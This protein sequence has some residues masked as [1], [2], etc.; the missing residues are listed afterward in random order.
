MTFL[1]LALLSFSCLVEKYLIF[2]VLAAAG[3]EVLESYACT[4]S[5]NI[6][7]WFAC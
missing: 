5:E 6:V 7:Y 2:R 4:I 3:N 1:I